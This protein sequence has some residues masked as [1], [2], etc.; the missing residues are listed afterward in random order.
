MQKYFFSYQN[1]QGRGTANKNL[2][3]M[4]LNKIILQTISQIIINT[5]FKAGGVN[6][7]LSTGDV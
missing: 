1:I 3:R 2:L 7:G 4:A 5:Y 6:V